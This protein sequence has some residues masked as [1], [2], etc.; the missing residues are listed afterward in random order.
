M[1][2]CGGASRCSIPTGDATGGVTNRWQSSP[3][4]VPPSEPTVLSDFGTPR[5]PRRSA[6]SFHRASLPHF[7][8]LAS[9]HCLLQ[10]LFIFAARP[11]TPGTPPCRIVFFLI[12]TKFR[13]AYKQ[14]QLC[15][16]V[17][18]CFRKVAPQIG[19]VNPSALPFKIRATQIGPRCIR[20]PREVHCPLTY[21]PTIQF[22][23]LMFF[24][25]F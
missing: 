9:I 12:P 6:S 19:K 13:P 24:F 18:V 15:C 8:H 16:W 4:G 7:L 20:I 14:T 10:S 22:S 17:G 3:R 1:L 25:C 2:D 5:P 23:E 21:L 11:E